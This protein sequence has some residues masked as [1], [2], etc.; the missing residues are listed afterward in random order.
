MVLVASEYHGELQKRPQMMKERKKAIKKVKKNISTKLQESQVSK[1]EKPISKEE[2][3]EA[4]K[5]TEINKCP[6]PSGITY[7]F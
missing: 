6:G 7:E 5:K 4:I 3:L 1:M 2:I